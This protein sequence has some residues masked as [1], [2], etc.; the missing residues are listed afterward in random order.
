[1]MEAW[2]APKLPHRRAG[3]LLCCT[4][5]LRQLILFSGRRVKVL[6]THVPGYVHGEGG[7]A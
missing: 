3:A 1:M 5:C 7:K 4:T 2:L 6:G